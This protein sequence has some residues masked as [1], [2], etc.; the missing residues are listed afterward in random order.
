MAKNKADIELLAGL[1]INSS[2]QEILNAIKILQKK[3][4]NNAKSR[5]TLNPDIDITLMKN[6]LKT[7]QKLI[8]REDLSLNTKD[9][10]IS[11]Q[12]ES[13]AML[14]IVQ[15]A[16]K[17]AKEKLS[18]AK[19]NEKVKKSA[20]NTASAINRERNA[21]G[22]LDDLDYILANIN[23]HGAS[24]NNVFQTFG[25]TLN[26]AFSTYTVANL[27]TDSIRKAVNAG[28]EAIDTIKEFDDI[29]VNLQLA[30]G[31][32]KN[33]VK[34]MISDYSELGKEL[35]SLTQSVAES[36]DT[37]LRQ[38][39]SIEDT[40]RL[41]KD[42]TILSK[43]A[44]IDGENASEILTATINGFQLAASEGSRVND[45]LSSIDL[46]SA[47]DASGIG[48]SLTKVASIA[49]N[50]GVSLEK[51]A[52]MIATI[53]NATQ[54]DDATIGTSL[55]TVLSR[56]NSI[57]AGK[58][59]D[60]ETG[61]A[62]NDVEK[63]LNK[64]S[65]SMRDA[66]GQFQDAEI[67]LDAVGN[68]WKELDKNTQKA[69]TTAMG[70]V[71]QAN[72]LTALFDN[73]SQVIELTK[74]AENSQGQSLEKFNNSYLPSLEAK[75]NAL[76]SSIQSLETATI[77]DELYASI[78]DTSKVMV[79]LTTSTGIL[80]GLLAGIGTSGSIYMF[81]QLA[82][83]LGDATQGFANFNEAMSMTR[84]GSVG[85][86]DMQRL[87][88]LTG[89][90]SQSQTRLLISTNTLTDA[91]K[92]AILVNQNLAQ[93]MSQEVAEATARATLNTWGLASAQQA[94]TTATVTLD[95]VLKGI[96]ATLMANPL[97]LVTA[98]VTAGA[99][100]FNAYKTHVE[101]VRRTTEESATAFRESSSSIDDYVAKY[102]DL[103]RALLEAKGDEQATYDI[104]KQLLELQNELN[105]KFGTEASKINL[106]SDAYRDQTEAIKAYN[107]E[108][109]S[110]YLNENRKGIQTA[111][112]QMTK[113]REY[114][115]SDNGIS[116][117][118]ASG[119]AVN[120]IVQKYS[121]KGISLLDSGAGTYQV[122]IKADAENAYEAINDFSNDLRERSK[123]LGNEHLFDGILDIS[124]KALNDA[125]DTVE[126]YGDIF[127]QALMANLV[128]DD[129]MSA[130]YN[131]A[132][133][134]VEQYNNAV[135]SSAD[136]YSDENVANAKKNLDEVRA[137]IDGNLEEWG[138]YSSITNALFEQADTKLIDFNNE[139]TSNKELIRDAMN[140]K[141][142]SDLDLEAFNT[143]EN[144]AFDRLKESA[145]EYG[146][147]VEQL[148]DTLARLGYIQSEVSNKSEDTF[149]VKT[150]SLKDL[151]EQID[152]IQSAYKALTSASEE[153]NQ[154][155]YVTAD[156][157][158]TLLS[159]DSQYLAC[160]ID[161]NGQLA[162]NGT[163][164]QNLVQAKLADCEATAVQQAIEELDALTKKQQ[165]ANTYD[166][167]EANALLAKSLSTLTGSYGA[168]AE[169]AAVAA[170]AQ[171]LSAALDNAKNRGADQ[172][173]IERVMSNL[174]V[175]L[176]LIRSTAKNT[177][178]SFGAMTNHLNGFSNASDKA[179][180]KTDALTKSMEK[181]KK[182]LEDTKSELE[183]QKQYYDD[184][185]SAVN[186]FYDKQ[187][188]KQEK[189]IKNLEKQNELIQ[190]QIDIRDGALSAIDRYHEKQ[191]K[192]LQDRIDAMDKANDA[193]EKEL[194]IEQAKQKLA[195]AKNHKTLKQYHK[196]KGFIYTVD[197]KAIKEAE[198]NLANATQEKLK[199][200]IQQEIE[201]LEEYRKLW[202]EIPNAKKESEEQSRMIS[203]LG[204]E[205]ESILLNGRIENIN[206]FKD[207]YISLQQKI[208]DNTS[209]IES[210]NQKI[211]YYESL[212]EQWEE[213]TSKYE[214]ETYTQLLISEFGNNFEDI[215]L[216]GR[217]ERWEQFA[218][219]YF[220]IQVELKDITDKIEDL[221]K[222]MEEYAARMES[223]ANKAASAIANIKN[224]DV[225]DVPTGKTY[226][227][228]GSGKIVSA[229]KAKG[230]IISKKDS[231]DLDYI[232]KP[233]GEDHM[234]G[235]QDG[236][237]VIPK[238]SVQRNPEVVNALINDE[239]NTPALPK[240]GSLAEEMGLIPVEVV[241]FGGKKFRLEDLQNQ[242]AEVIKKN[243]PPMNYGVPNFGYDRVVNNNQNNAT[244][245]SI[246]DIHL[247][248]VQNV[249]SLAEH[250][251][252]DMGNKVRQKTSKYKW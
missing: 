57:R 21:M 162:L 211:E 22:T 12:K 91:Q 180:D 161:E 124:S 182:A 148:I 237:A 51:T 173:D 225:P 143:G 208:D 217:T 73:Y 96:W 233:L 187:I 86:N 234:I 128:S 251:V 186:W 240:E 13:Q 203:Q 1:N 157:L 129:A 205:W 169:S 90:L 33:Y 197:Q 160:L 7:L 82:N 89:G 120:D 167:I 62:L 121:N 74:I 247:H 195:E 97:V 241:D 172:A 4:D 104:K 199:F 232:A 142:Y 75:T 65:I 84:N 135:A 235:I 242:F 213:L 177:A 58:F 60:E 42:S 101:E 40:N 118:T 47:S 3:F 8:K 5:I 2:E 218:D 224:V 185:I 29:N 175:K 36:S 67:I 147:S 80:K 127:K 215:L 210:Y 111:T 71:Y 250:I 156:T 6:T 94:A 69:V 30:T 200:D 216:N 81:R 146:L 214:E 24:G 191:Q 158:Q 166:Y 212:K 190:E 139:L 18:F 154:Y 245:I 95:G 26:D 63:V 25:R 16:N 52:S 170:Q 168:V 117:E 204:A 50:A 28:K 198:D 106:V 122:V 19:A 239:H 207:K 221:A 55:K 54:D 112:K 134:A 38:G 108:L 92:I 181:Q 11:I 230:G 248:E 79:D 102:Q 159:L 141:N 151:N 20:D 227:G 9:S 222:R 113:T 163:A 155:G 174:N 183:K 153:Y 110:R 229:V 149:F 192:E 184:V 123:E 68:K 99:M 165:E 231:G 244:N 226:Y 15:T 77:S 59:I 70:G 179:K 78:L 27:L 119:Q 43:I 189:Y 223:A 98:A 125:K 76:K 243:P 133:N 206:A 220:N 107:K 61:E 249:D 17:A 48:E 34:G 132:L 109:A 105:E 85:I 145:E 45:V 49:N 138:K 103:H 31:E 176:E 246:G 14:E 116:L 64:I 56:M 126:K 140:L 144:E 164:Y 219:D 87:I 152:S 137:K 171:A 238:E 114:T 193:A 72:K 53:K 130:V 10:I 37:F 196:D 188:S 252:R 228:G 35:G 23:M 39:R 194:A 100:A 88:D 115:L 83:Y 136:P 236:E 131:E 44:K 150:V 41:I 32:D 66:N 202:Q 178:G 209:M 46:N 201:K 93:G